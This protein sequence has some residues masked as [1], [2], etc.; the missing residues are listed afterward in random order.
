MFTGIIQSVG[1]VT[2]LTRRGADVRARI[3]GDLDLSK[4]CAGD[5]IAVNGVCLTVTERDARS[6]AADISAETQRCTTLGSL[7][8]GERVNLEPALAAGAPLGG[9]FVTGH[10]DGVGRVLSSR[11]EG[12]S[13]R[14]SIEAPAALAKYIAVKG[15]ICVDGVSLT[16]NEIAG[17]AF[18]VNFIPHTLHH[19]TLGD[20][21]AGNRVN[22]EVDIIARYLERLHTC[23]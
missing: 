15:S 1:A 6:F 13:L 2:E 11:P 9:H 22:L 4:I 19:T 23:R 14:V 20:R 12:A 7:K 5:S 16:V 21:H 17:N 18:S 10:V 3:G 8:P